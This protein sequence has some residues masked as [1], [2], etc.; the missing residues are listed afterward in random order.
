MVFLLIRIS[1]IL[2]ANRQ[3]IWVRIFTI[4][5]M[6]VLVFVLQFLVPTFTESLLDKAM[7]YISK[8]AYIYVWEYVMGA[9][10]LII[11]V[12]YFYIYKRS[13]SSFNDTLRPQTSAL[14][15]SI[16]IAI[17]FIGTFTF[18]QRTVCFI[19]SIL[20]IPFMLMLLSNKQAVRLSRR[21]GFPIKG[22]TFVFALA[23]LA[24]SCSRGSLCGLKFFE[25]GA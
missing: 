23:E 5:G 6:I 19:I 25:L 18:F 22:L 16:V 7:G 12:Y 8:E 10:I 14:F 17:A 13:K 21:F 4:I 9:L 1:A 20:C 3:N 11:D 15:M 24:V 2:F